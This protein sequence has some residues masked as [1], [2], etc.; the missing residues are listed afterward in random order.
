M[1]PD[2]VV[3]VQAARRP[4]DGNRV[5]TAV[6]K[7][8]PGTAVGAKRQ[9]KKKRKKKK[10]EK[11]KQKKK[12]DAGCIVDALHAACIEWLAGPAHLHRAAAQR[13]KQRRKK[14]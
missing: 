14:E 11:K 12:V 3:A 13:Q 8:Y 6:G 4:Q 7:A 5:L 2:C 9:K 10:K 1:L